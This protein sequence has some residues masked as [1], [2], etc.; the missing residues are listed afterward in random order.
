MKASRADLIIENGLGLELWATKFIAAAGEVR[1][2]VLSE[3]MRPLLI[4]SDAYAG[5]PNPHAW[6]SPRRAMAYTDRLL[7]A[8][9]RL[10]PAGEDEF[11]LNARQY[12]E[13]L[14]VLDNDLRESLASIPVSR[15]C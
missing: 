4:E 2:V 5:K 8:F 7:E 14:Q 12:K 11:R 3:G 6:M 10:D 15:N 13:K 1:S 9:I